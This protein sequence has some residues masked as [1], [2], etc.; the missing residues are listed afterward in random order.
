MLVNKL[1]N[2]ICFTIEHLKSLLD[3]YY[4]ALLNHLIF[5]IT[6]WHYQYFFYFFL[7]IQPES[8]AL[9]L[10]QK[11]SLAQLSYFLAPLTLFKVHP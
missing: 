2:K 11:S 5:Q 10:Q 9:K 4:L 8:L 3:L 7:F 1:Y 6:I